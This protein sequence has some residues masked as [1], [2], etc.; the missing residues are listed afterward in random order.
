MK[1]KRRKWRF[2]RLLLLLLLLFPVQRK[3][4]ERR[5]IQ[6]LTSKGQAL[7]SGQYACAACNSCP[8][9]CGCQPPTIEELAPVDTIV[10]TSMKQVILIHHRN[11]PAFIQI[12][13]VLSKT[14]S[15]F[16]VFTIVF[17]CRYPRRFWCVEPGGLGG[18]GPSFLRRRDAALSAGNRLV[19]DAVGCRRRQPHRWRFHRKIACFF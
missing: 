13:W 14:W 2:S 18:A 11:L 8:V 17:F 7:H 19:V 12:E 1:K 15:Y 3:F 9:G 6:T 5:A 10:I 4:D 16:P